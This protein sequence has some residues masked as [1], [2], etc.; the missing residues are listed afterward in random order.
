MPTVAN[1]DVVP[2]DPRCDC[3]RDSKE[4]GAQW[5]GGGPDY[6]YDVHGPRLD[7]VYGGGGAAP[8]VQD[9]NAPPT[10][11]FGS[12]PTPAEREAHKKKVCNRMVK[13]ALDMGNTMRFCT[14]TRDK[15]GLDA[16]APKYIRHIKKLGETCGEPTRGLHYDYSGQLN[17]NG[18]GD[19]Y[20]G[21]GAPIADRSLRIAAELVQRKLMWDQQVL[22]G[23][24]TWTDWLVNAMGRRPKW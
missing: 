3:E 6:V 15:A 20:D 16:M 11:R 14:R 1:C 12:H 19:V 8:V 22:R 10:V 17:G 2:G 7:V 5:Y 9:S 18:A 24:L 21:S 13:E 4:P 23:Q